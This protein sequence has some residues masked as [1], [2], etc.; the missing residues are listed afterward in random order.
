MDPLQIVGLIVGFAASIFSAFAFYKAGSFKRTAP[1]EK[2]AEAG[3]GWVNNTSETSVRVLAWLE[4]LGAIGIVLAPIAAIAGFGFA[5]TF[6]VAAGAGLSL[7]MVA[8][9]VLHQRRGESKLTL[10]MNLGLL[11]PALIAT[12][13]WVLFL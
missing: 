12:V 11:A 2:L 6:A 4:I 1:I 3:M 7:V 13:A 8:A 5:K 10:K 9:I